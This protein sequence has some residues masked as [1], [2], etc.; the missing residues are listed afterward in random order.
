MPSI[1]SG[2]A[3]TEYKEARTAG[4]LG[5]VTAV[6]GLIISIGAG[7]AESFGVDTKTGIVVGGLVTVAG[8]I[9]KTLVTLGYVKSRTD[10]KTLGK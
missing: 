2:K 5:M 1:K 6:C 10:V 3:T 4:I 8:V 7:I 9:Q